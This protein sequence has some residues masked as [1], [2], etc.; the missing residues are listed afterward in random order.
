MPSSEPEGMS[1]PEVVP[2]NSSTTR[3]LWFPP[4]RPNGAITGYH[5]YVNDHLH[6]SVDNSS[7]SY[8]LGNLLPFTV[9]SVQVHTQTKENYRKVCIMFCLTCLFMYFRWRCVLCM[10]VWGVMLLRQL[11]WRTCLLTWSHHTHKWSVPGNAEMHCEY[12]FSYSFMLCIC[13][14]QLLVWV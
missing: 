14:T 10:H 2:V 7:G 11:L 3:V 9:Y 6:G 8:L 12:W 5:I 1:A 13:L 4:Q